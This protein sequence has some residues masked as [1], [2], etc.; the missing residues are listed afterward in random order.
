MA[1]DPR[2]LPEELVPYAD[3]IDVRCARP[4]WGVGWRAHEWPAPVVP[5]IPGAP[6]HDGVHRG[7]WISPGVCARLELRAVPEELRERLRA[8]HAAQ[9]GEDGALY[10]FGIASRSQRR[11]VDDALLALALAL[12]GVSSTRVC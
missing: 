5:L 8:A 3:A 4:I 2:R 7:S 6:P 12:V 1:I 10:A 11:N 9:V